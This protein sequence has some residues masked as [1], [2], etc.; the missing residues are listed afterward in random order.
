VTVPAL[1]LD[2]RFSMLKANFFPIRDSVT[3]CE[4]LVDGAI[5]DDSSFA[6]QSL[7]GDTVRLAYDYLKTNVLQ[8]ISLY[9][10]GSMWGFDTLLYACDTAII[11]QPGV[12]A[13]YTVILK[14]VGPG[15]PP[16]GSATMTA[17]LG[18]VGTVVING[19]LQPSNPNDLD[20]DVFMVQIQ[21]GTFQM[22]QAGPVSNPADSIGPRHS[23][24]LT[25]NFWLDVEP[26]NQTSY[27][28]FMHLIPS[29]FDGGN[30]PVEQVTWFDAV[31]YCNARSK[32][33]G[34]DTVY[35][36]TGITGTP[37]NGCTALAGLV[38]DRAKN[39]Y[40]LPTEAQWEYA[41]RGGTTT[42]YYW[43]A[44]YPPATAAD[45][46]AINQNAVWAGN[47]YNLG[48]LN[49]NYGTH[50][51][52]I[53]DTN[54][55]GLRCMSGNVWEWCNDWSTAYTGNAAQTDPTGPARGRYRV[56][57]GGSWE[58]NAAEIR[59]AYRNSGAPGSR[60]NSIGF[61]VALPAQ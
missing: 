25:Q 52:S 56:L 60:N 48:P 5:V 39:G 21:A 51:L 37:G 18:E 14:W 42:P 44:N 45:T 47:S 16:T 41:C 24:T 27:F 58:S 32:R 12:N 40:R 57:R 34:F 46:A 17:A 3:R 49:F 11:A 13:S 33:D 54:S 53:Q 29:H 19:N 30:L 38:M 2:S 43:S 10:Y 31:L 35:A 4:L 50:A 15:F 55:Y 7:I 9:A 8:H 59:S 20:T 23:V 22:G 61:R 26:V 36:Y 28:S 1:D 6:K